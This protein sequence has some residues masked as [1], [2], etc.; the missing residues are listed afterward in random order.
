MGSKVTEKARRLGLS[1]S[2]IYKAE[3]EGRLATVGRTK[4]RRPGNPKPVKVFNRKWGTL[5][6][7]CADLGCSE[8]T[9]RTFIRGEASDAQKAAMRDRFDAWAAKQRRNGNGLRTSDRR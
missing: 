5:A 8:P 1:T 4:R 9:L 7:C 2:A 3:R 6:L